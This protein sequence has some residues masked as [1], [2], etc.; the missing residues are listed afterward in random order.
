MP[1]LDRTLGQGLRGQGQGRKRRAPHGRGLQRL[2]C[3]CHRERGV[4]GRRRLQRRHGW[5]VRAWS[6]L[7]L[8]VKV[9]VR[10]QG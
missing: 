6:G 4:L 9:R 2:G 1:Q 3:H 5:R 8:G 10:G 7:G